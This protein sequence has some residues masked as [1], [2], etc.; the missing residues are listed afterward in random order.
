MVVIP[1]FYTP[2]GRQIDSSDDYY[3][4][5]GDFNKLSLNNLYMPYVKVTDM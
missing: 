4:A 1:A 2:L 3:G 5:S